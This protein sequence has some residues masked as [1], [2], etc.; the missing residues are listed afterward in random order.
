MILLCQGLVDKKDIESISISMFIVEKFNRFNS[1]GSPRKLDYFF[2]RTGWLVLQEDSLK[3]VGWLIYKHK[4]A[5]QEEP[6]KFL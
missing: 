1:R 4:A 5:L 2:Y 3:K 6:L